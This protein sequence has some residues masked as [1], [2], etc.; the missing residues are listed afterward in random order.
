M[1]KLVR[2]LKRMFP[3]ATIEMTH[4]NHYRLILRNGRVVVVSNSAS[5]RNFMR[6]VIA[7]VRRQSKTDEGPAL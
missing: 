5:D 6:N 3:G 2:D 1:R 7:D 4:R